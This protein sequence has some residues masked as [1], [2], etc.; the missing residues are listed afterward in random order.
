[1]F[2][3]ENILLGY[4]FQLSKTYDVVGGARCTTIQTDLIRKY[5]GS[6]NWKA[7]VM[8]E[9]LSGLVNPVG[10]S[11][12]QELSFFPLFCSAFLNISF[13]LRLLFSPPQ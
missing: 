3:I 6:Q 5:V 8:W 2:F 13:I 1:M 12:D 4:R 7:R 10:K 11:C 9:K